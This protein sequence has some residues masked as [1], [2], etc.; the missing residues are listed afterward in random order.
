MKKLGT[1]STPARQKAAS[2]GRD[3]TD[4]RVASGK[5]SNSQLM[6]SAT[7]DST[8]KKSGISTI[9]PSGLLPTAAR[10]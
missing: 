6:R 9:E 8:L 3:R 4:D 7:Y 1:A 2:A 5:A 10:Q